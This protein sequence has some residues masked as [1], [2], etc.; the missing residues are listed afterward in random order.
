[1]GLD[2]LHS[3]IGLCFRCRDEARIHVAKPEF[4]DRGPADARVMG[5][6]MAPG[7]SAISAQKAFAGTSLKK[8]HQWFSKAGYQAPT[9]EA[10]RNRLYLTSLIKC[11][12]IPD[13][14]STR[15]KMFRH[16]QS[17]LWRQIEQIKPDLILL[18]GSE[19]VQTISP[20][21]LIE[22][23]LTEV[24]GNYW[25]TEEMFEDTFFPLTHCECL[26]LCLP[27]PSGLSRVMNDPAISKNV[28]AALGACLSQVK[29]NYDD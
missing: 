27:H 26:W 5:I 13:K 14:A 7:A 8:I 28:I 4:M 23:K 3:E 12:A 15:H 20:S 16:C 6:G 1:M 21:K 18:F 2:A 9:Q 24:V 29:F 17:Y 22:R 25:T 10:L 11:A 19:V